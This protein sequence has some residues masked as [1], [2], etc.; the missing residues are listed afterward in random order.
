MIIKKHTEFKLNN[1]MFYSESNIDTD[2]DGYLVI[3]FMSMTTYP[4][5]DAMPV[6]QLVCKTLEEK[7]MIES[8]FVVMGGVKDICLI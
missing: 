1:K 7:Y 6:K 5:V 2:Y 3:D 8:T 4:N